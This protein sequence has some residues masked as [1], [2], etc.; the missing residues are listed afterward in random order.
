MCWLLQDDLLA[1]AGCFKIDQDKDKTIKKLKAICKNYK[2][3][4]GP[5]LPSCL[6]VSRN[7]FGG[8]YTIT[9]NLASRFPSA[10]SPT[11]K[12]SPSV[13][14]LSLPYGGGHVLHHRLLLSQ[15]LQ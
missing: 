7:K 12:S 3:I 6:K 10:W 14:I 13:V 4:A 11:S 15:S 2:L 5:G 8:A 1:C 9:I